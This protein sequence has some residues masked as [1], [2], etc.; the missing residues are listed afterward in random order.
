[1]KKHTEHKVFQV[2]KGQPSALTYG[3]KIRAKRRGKARG[4]GNQGRYSKP[5]VTK[6]KMTGKKQ[7][8]KTD[9]KF[10][11]LVC[12]KA[13]TQAKGFRAKRVELV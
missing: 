4:F 1:C 7:T 6:F 9:L 5:A 12:K 13:H 3:S 11:C 10:Q 2:K 8:K